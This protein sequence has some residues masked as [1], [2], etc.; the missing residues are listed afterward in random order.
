MKLFLL[1]N[2]HLTHVFSNFRKVSSFCLGFIGFWLCVTTP[3]FLNETVVANQ[4]AKFNIFSIIIDL[5]SPEIITA[6]VC[7]RL[8]KKPET[9]SQK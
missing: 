8:S 7:S 1:V 3:L 6:V 9:S 4:R 2:S 5:E